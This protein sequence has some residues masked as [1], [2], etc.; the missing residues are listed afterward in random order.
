MDRSWTAL[1]KR[2]QNSQRKGPPEP[3][4]KSPPVPLPHMRLSED[5]DPW[6]SRPG[7]LQCARVLFM[8]AHQKRLMLRRW[9]GPY[10]FNVRTE[11]CPYVATCDGYSPTTSGTGRPIH[12]CHHFM[13]E[14]VHLLPEDWKDGGKWFPLRQPVLSKL[15]SGLKNTVVKPKFILNIISS[16]DNSRLQKQTP[17]N[18][19]MWLTLPLNV[20]IN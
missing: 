7:C 15:R 3:S 5:G 14:I 8:H 13:V 20:I 17:S 16:D 4:S 6:G 11:R 18:N 1:K 2:P 19:S 10:L 12:F 9:M